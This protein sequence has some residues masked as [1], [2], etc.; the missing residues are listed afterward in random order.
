[1]LKTV[2]IR[3]LQRAAEILGGVDALRTY[4]NVSTFRLEAWLDGRA[5]PPDAVFLRVVDL[6]SADAGKEARPGDGA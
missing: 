6:L 4:L 1:M 2:Q 3:A 5:T